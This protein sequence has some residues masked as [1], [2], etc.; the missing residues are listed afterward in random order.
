MCLTYCPRSGGARG[1]VR[2]HEGVTLCQKSDSLWPPRQLA[3]QVLPVLSPDDYTTLPCQTTAARLRAAGYEFM[4]TV[5]MASNARRSFLGQ[6][7][8]RRV[9][10]GLVVPMNPPRDDTMPRRARPD[11]VAGFPY[12]PLPADGSVVESSW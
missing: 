3:C 5:T 11:F 2:F 7:P 1:N 8:G 6:R 12:L 4:K 9:R 10:G